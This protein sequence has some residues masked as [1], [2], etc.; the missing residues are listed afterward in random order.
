VPIGAL[1]GVG[2][3]LAPA[4]PDVGAPETTPSGGAGML[5]LAPPC[6][7]DGLPDCGGVDHQGAELPLLE[8][9]PLVSSL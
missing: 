1:A 8:G 7:V 2:R 6:E 9:S 4:L 3:L 5:L